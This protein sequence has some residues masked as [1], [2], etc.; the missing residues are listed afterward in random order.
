[1]TKVVIFCDIRITKK[2]IDYKT[3]AFL[4]KTH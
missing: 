1:M 3:N 2:D 4:N